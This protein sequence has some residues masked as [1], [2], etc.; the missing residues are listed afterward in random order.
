[1]FGV[2]S[3][4]CRGLEAVDPEVVPVVVCDPA[5]VLEPDEGAVV[6]DTRGWK[7][8]RAARAGVAAIDS[9]MSAAART[10]RIFLIATIVR[11]LVDKAP[12]GISRVRSVLGFPTCPR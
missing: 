5:A 10:T 2:P 12:A 8:S 11:R 4:G 3:T 1:M 7:G 6:E 9:P